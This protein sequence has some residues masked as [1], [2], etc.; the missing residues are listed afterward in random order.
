MF[1]D[2]LLKGARQKVAVGRIVNAWDGPGAHEVVQVARQVLE[3]FPDLQLLRDLRGRQL[4]LVFCCQVVLG[5]FPTLLHLLE[6]QL[7]AVEIVDAAAAPVASEPLLD[8]ARAVVEEVLPQPVVALEVH[9]LRPAPAQAASHHALDQLRGRYNLVIHDADLRRPVVGLDL[10]N[11]LDL[12]R[13]SVAGCLRQLE[14]VLRHLLF[15]CLHCK[16]VCHACPCRGR[17]SLRAYS[18]GVPD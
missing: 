17:S 4:L 14:V 15:S 12:G 2:G 6:V 11:R 18:V 10:G 5:P 3:L 8:G 16:Q 1:L 9:R 7:P 13:Q